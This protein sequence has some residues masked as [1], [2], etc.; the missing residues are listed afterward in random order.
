M[1]KALGPATP[2][3]VVAFLSFLW[4]LAHAQ[5]PDDTCLLQS[6]KKQTPGWNEAQGGTSCY[7]TCHSVGLTCDR[8]K[9]TTINSSQ[10]IYD[11]VSEH[12][13]EHCK[14]GFE[15]ADQLGILYAGGG[16]RNRCAYFDSESD[17]FDCE[18]PISGAT[19]SYSV[20]YCS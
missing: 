15:K 2:A 6:V 9:M 12:F 16:D 4:A 7:W 5:C 10:A 20:C 18:D 11:V 8:T 14:A 1:A 17:Y 3:V 13:G 19:N